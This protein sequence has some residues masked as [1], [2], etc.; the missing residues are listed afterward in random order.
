[1]T[2]RTNLRKWGLLFTLMLSYSGGVYS[3]KNNA[4]QS[5]LSSHQAELKLTSS[6]LSNWRIS[7]QHADEEKGIHYIYAQQQVNG[8]DVYNALATFALM[9][10]RVYLTGNNWIPG[11]TSKSISKDPKIGAEMAVRH[12]YRNLGLTEPTYFKLIEQGENSFVFEKGEVSKED[13]PV[14]LMYA[15]NEANELRLVWDLSIYNGSD[16]WWSLRIDAEN[17]TVVNQTDWVISCQFGDHSQHKHSRSYRVKEQAQTNFG[18]LLLPPPT[19][20]QYNVFP[21]P[22][23]SPNHGSR[24]LVIGPFDVASSPYGWHDDNGVAGNEYTITRG[25]NVHAQED[26]NDNNGTGYSPSGGAS[27]NFDFPLNLNQNPNN[28]LDP[29]ITNL[30]YMNNIMHDVYYHYGFTEAAGNFQENNYGNGGIASDMVYADAQDG[31]GTNNANFA[32]PVDGSN[33]RMQMYLWDPGITNLLTVNSP[34]SIA[35]GY[36]AVEA[37][38]GSP[39]PATPI[40]SNLVLY[41]DNA[42]L[43]PN[44]ACENPTAANAAAQ[45]GKIV[46]IYRGDCEFGAKVLKAQQAGAVAVIMIN[47]VAGSPISMGAGAQGGSVTIPSVMITDVDGAAIVAQMALGTVNATLV[48]NGSFQSDGD[49][50][51][52]IIAHEYGHGISKRLTGGAGNASCLSNSEQMGEGWSDWFGLMLTIE[53][54]DQATDN[55]GVGTYVTGESTTGVGIRPAPYNVNF[56]VNNYTY[57]ATNN[58]GSISQPHGIGFVWCTMLWDMT[59]ALID[60]YGYDPDVYTGTG[61]NN[62]AMNLVVTALK[63]QPCSPGFVDGRDAILAADQ[64]LYNG[65][66][67]CLI[68][69]AFATR[70]CGYSASQGSAN[71]RTDQTE[72]FDM[73]PSMVNVTG[74]E[75][76]TSCGAFTWPANGV[77]YTGSGSYTADLF[78]TTGCDSIVTLNLTVANNTTGNATASGCSS[79]TWPTSGQTYTA[80]GNYSD[81]LTSANGCDSIV[82]LNLTI[83]NPYN[84]TEVVSACSNYFWPATGQTYSTS[85]QYV[86]NLA[87]IHGCDSIVTLDLTMSTVASSVQNVNSCGPYTWGLNNTTYNAST[88]DQVQLV[89]SSGCDSIVTLNLTV[90]A[91]SASTQ[92]ATSCNSYTWNVNNTTYTNSGQYTA[93]IPNAAGC[94]SVITLD[95]TINTSV[96][97]AT[98]VI[99]NCGSYTWPVNNISYANSGIYT[100]TLSTVNGCDSIVTLDL[101]VNQSSSSTDSVTACGS[102]TWSANNQTYTTAGNYNTT[103]PNAAGCDSNMTLVLTINTVNTGIA[104]LD[105]ITLGANQNGATYQWLDCNNN[106]APVAGETNQSLTPTANGSYCCAVTINGC[107]DT[108]DC[109]IISK[110]GLDEVI[111]DDQ[112]LIYP[113]PSNDGVITVQ[114]DG[115]ITA[116]EVVDMTGRKVSEIVQMKENTIDASKLSI[117]NYMIHFTT[118]EGVITKDLTIIR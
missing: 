95:L 37:A 63:L 65:A 54:G 52:M 90:N 58:T 34:S 72:A 18:P 93:T 105:I 4:V 6:D 31:G 118:D 78:T 17:G 71:S 48:N 81:T 47:N 25:N 51:N 7:D 1:M 39:V 55:R 32:T 77:T 106:F 97:G 28:Y 13:I 56:A 46:V 117:G 104:Y 113:N 60:K 101:T 94:D 57:A 74:T 59:W 86:A 2:M 12:A 41:D 64:M 66:N 87:S 112:L 22:V 75:T 49:F 99:N 14:K 43:D 83:Y 98:A 89:A 92:S 24:A 36:G 40:T 116:I 20:D 27:L 109:R 114:Y 26:M 53:P 61:G 35:G 69:N 76:V 67:Q 73:P 115:Q 5:Y 19:T 111:S 103:I 80:S 110:V 108:T 29:A 85:G 42:G 9:G 33:P 107:T 11:V 44:D 68:W 70:G 15:V 30:F 79:Y 45:N 3:Q 10:D 96:N 8:L 50:D 16:H 100:A 62:V 23:E 84:T 38:F 21:I 88:T 91:P 82:T 102:Y